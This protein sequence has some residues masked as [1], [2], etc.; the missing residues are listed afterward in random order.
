MGL[1]AKRFVRGH[2]HVPQRWQTY[3]DYSEYP[4]LTINAMGRRMDGEPDPAEGPHPFPVMAR[5][6]PDQLPV[7]VQLPL[8]ARE[9]NRAMGKEPP[10][11]NNGDG[12]RGE[13]GPSEALDEIARGVQ[14]DAEAE[15]MLKK[16]PNPENR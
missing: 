8:D 5:H 12:T 4:V 6:V 11:G 16:S 3:P 2:D 14:L 7:V 1:P 15:L 13:P 10:A 9:V